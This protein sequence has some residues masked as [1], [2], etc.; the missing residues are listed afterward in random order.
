MKKKTSL[1]LG[2]LLLAVLAAIFYPQL[3]EADAAARPAAPPARSQPHAG[4]E[5]PGKTPAATIRGI[6]FTSRGS[7]QSHFDKHGAEFGR[8]SIDE[9][10]ALA[11]RL[12]DAPLSADVLENVR[13]SDGVTTRFDRKGGGFVA[14][15]DDRTIRTFFRPND[16]EAYFRRQGAR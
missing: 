11:Q 13:D 8:I 15:H 9:Y 14:F 16:G 7:L 4:A 12:R 5:A 10:L 3:L 6:G 1:S 2:G